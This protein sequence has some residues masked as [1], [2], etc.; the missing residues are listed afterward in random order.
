M[1]TLELSSQHFTQFTKEPQFAPKDA[2]KEIR[3]QLHPPSVPEQRVDVALSGKGGATKSDEFSGKFQTAFDPPPSFSENYVAIVF[4]TDM[5][6][7]ICEG[8]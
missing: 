8:V 6:A 7:Y 5:V 3:S 4:M 2:T 1:C